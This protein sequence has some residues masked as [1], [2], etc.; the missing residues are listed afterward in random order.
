MGLVK[1]RWRK[2]IW[3]RWPPL[4]WLCL[5][6]AVSAVFAQVDGFS[7]HESAAAMLIPGM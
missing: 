6:L 2:P 4:L 7:V 5:F 3:R 1:T